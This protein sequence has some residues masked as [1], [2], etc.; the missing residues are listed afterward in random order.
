M[1]ES[2][3]ITQA[4]R[5]IMRAVIG[6]AMQEIVLDLDT[7]VFSIETYEVFTPEG[8]VRIK[9]AV[10]NFFQEISLVMKAER[11]ILNIRKSD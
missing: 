8:T 2:E 10:L 11:D 4:A 5:N 3:E 6:K 7:V 9:D 1:T